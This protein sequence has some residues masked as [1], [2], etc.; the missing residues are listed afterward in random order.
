MTKPALTLLAALLGA[1]GS[2]ACSGGPSCTGD[3]D[4]F[5]QSSGTESGSRG[6]SDNGAQNA[7]ETESP[8]TQTGSEAEKDGPTCVGT[9]VCWCG[10]GMDAYGGDSSPAGACSKAEGATWCCASAAY[11]S[12]G[13]C[14]CTNVAPNCHRSVFG[15]SCTCS[16]V[17]PSQGDTPVSTCTAKTGGVCCNDPDDAVAMCTCWDKL[18][19]CPEGR[20]QVSSCTPSSLRCESRAVDSC[21]P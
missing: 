6:S 17:E 20:E 14:Y 12:S 5:N 7:E 1:S 16:L 3:C 13:A 8:P 10:E 11:P 19:V 15:D 9:D 4:S 18:S 21:R 2:L